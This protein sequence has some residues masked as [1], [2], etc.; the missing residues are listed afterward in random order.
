MNPFKILQIRKNIKDARENPSIFAGG[1]VKDFLWGVF[2]LPIIVCILILG[3]FFVIGFTD[4]FGFQIGFFKFLFW[5]ALF[6]SFIFFSVIRRIIGSISKTTT[7]Q[8]T[9]IIEAVVVEEKDNS[10]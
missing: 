3:I 7:K 5:V 6:M 4:L 9:K 2:V 1:Q 8:T 10:L